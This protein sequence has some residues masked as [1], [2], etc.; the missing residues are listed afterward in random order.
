MEGWGTAGRLLSG[1][2]LPVDAPCLRSLVE[3]SLQVT[4]L[5]RKQVT[6]GIGRA[7]HL[8]GLVAKQ[9]LAPRAAP[10]H[11]GQDN[12][13]P[14]CR[15]AMTTATVLAIRGAEKQAV[16]AEDV[17][18]R[19]CAA[20]RRRDQRDQRRRAIMRIQE[21]A[22]NALEY[23]WGLGTATAFFSSSLLYPEYQL[24]AAFDSA[25]EAKDAATLLIRAERALRVSRRALHNDKIKVARSEL[26][27]SGLAITQ[28]D[29]KCRAECWYIGR[30][31][32][33]RVTE[34]ARLLKAVLQVR[35]II[36]KAH[37]LL[38]LLTYKRRSMDF[39]AAANTAPDT[40]HPGVVPRKTKLKNRVKQ[41]RTVASNIKAQIVPADKKEYASSPMTRVVPTWHWEALGLGEPEG[42]QRSGPEE[43]QQSSV[44]PAPL[45]DLSFDG[46][47]AWRASGYRRIGV[48]AASNATRRARR[49]ASRL[50]SRT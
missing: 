50:D 45:L 23:G 22:G 34:I 41:A 39:T 16:I 24:Q 21:T 2:R 4:T 6:E 48:G 20:R 18:K 27:Q 9:G 31:F 10:I 25:L 37:R 15:L 32:G 43:G 40:A 33:D 19:V 29:Y 30:P 1:R 36:L 28:L 42:G 26:E 38:R 8:A 3:R 35:C 44:K 47:L 13:W 11:P 5:L 46:S 7:T 12:F 17:I 49:A 14:A